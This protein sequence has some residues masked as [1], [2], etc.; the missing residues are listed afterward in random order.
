MDGVQPI[1]SLR[2]KQKGLNEQNAEMA[3]KKVV[4]SMAQCSYKEAGPISQS[5]A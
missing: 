3:L 5:L 2:W 1:T 4:S